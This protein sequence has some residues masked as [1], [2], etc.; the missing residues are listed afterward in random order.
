M[1]LQIREEIKILVPIGPL[2]IGEILKITDFNNRSGMF[3]AVN[4]SG[5]EA[6]LTMD[7]EGRAWER[8]GLS[9]RS[10]TIDQIANDSMKILN[11]MISRDTFAIMG[12]DGAKIGPPIGI[13]SRP[14]HFDKPPAPEPI[15]FIGS[16][17]LP[18]DP[19]VDNCD[20]YRWR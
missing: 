14:P 6:Y 10:I 19:D 5:I 8:S 3:R 1:S 15:P 9:R 11:D 12:L 2:K 18:Y 16:H 13:G 4:V 17:N 7:G 20:D